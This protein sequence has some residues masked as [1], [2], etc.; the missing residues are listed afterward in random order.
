MLGRDDTSRGEVVAAVATMTRRIA[1]EDA[2]SGA[3]TE[4]VGCHGAE[5]GVAK[6]PQDPK[7][8][9]AWRYTKEKLM[10]RHNTGSAARPLIQ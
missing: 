4:F 7:H 3:R 5:V 10:W 1:E 8:V 6:A 9:V 2:G